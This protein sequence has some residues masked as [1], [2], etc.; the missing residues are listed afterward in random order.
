MIRVLLDKRAQDFMEKWH[1]TATEPASNDGMRRDYSHRVNVEECFRFTN[2]EEQDEGF[3]YDL[4]VLSKSG[5][6]PAVDCTADM[7]VFKE[8]FNLVHCRLREHGYQMLNYD[9]YYVVKTEVRRLLEFGNFVTAPDEEALVSATSLESF[10]AD[11][12]TNAMTYA[13]FVELLTEQGEHGRE[14]RLARALGDYSFH[15][16]EVKVLANSIPEDAAWRF[17][18]KRVA[19][20]DLL[21]AGEITAEDVRQTLLSYAK[22]VE[23]K[24]K[25]FLINLGG[26]EQYVMGLPDDAVQ[27][28]LGHCQQ[29]DGTL[30]LL[31]KFCPQHISWGSI[32]LEKMRETDLDLLIQG[33]V[34][35]FTDSQWEFLRQC[36]EKP[37]LEQKIV[38]N[39]GVLVNDHYWKLSGYLHQAKKIDVFRSVSKYLLERDSERISFKLKVKP[40]LELGYEGMERRDYDTYLQVAR[41]LDVSFGDH[42]KMAG[43][44]LKVGVT[45][46]VE[47]A[48]LERFLREEKIGGMSIDLLNGYLTDAYKE[49]GFAPGLEWMAEA[50]ARKAE[51]ARQRAIAENKSNDDVVRYVQKSGK[52]AVCVR[53]RDL[54]GREARSVKT[55]DGV[56][57]GALKAEEKRVLFIEGRINDYLID[58]ERV[59]RKVHGGILHIDV[60]SDD[61][62]YV[63]GLKGSKLRETTNRLQGLGCSLSTIRVHQS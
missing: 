3:A 19:L 25:Y 23:G 36:A 8:H 45:A 33:G 1:Y 63:I 42:N 34:S 14:F 31:R 18:M 49:V 54:S 46:G 48:E 47:T 35:V 59:K 62:G 60:L 58:V 6:A 53:T 26:I 12:D 56:E 22:R 2:E 5:H 4:Q 55:T 11:E 52:M 28:I 13:E 43:F 17:K 15:T 16:A 37:E 44:V 9:A 10:L 29:N 57:I 38:A 7:A 30:D 39:A 41:R 61:A 32:P 27:T 40:L 20:A 21:A 51:E 24:S 50:E